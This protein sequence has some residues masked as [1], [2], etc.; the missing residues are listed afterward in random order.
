M[1]VG[2]LSGIAILVV[3]D[4]EDAR[5][6]LVTV[7]TKQGAK[8]NEA[9]SCAEALTQLDQFLPQVLLSDIGL[10]GE[11]GYDL[12]RAVRARGYDAQTLPAIALTA[13]A[14]REDRRLALEAG[15][16][17]HVAKPVEP[18]ELVAVVARMVAPRLG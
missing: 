14:R 7:L 5:D 3:E 8:V 13:Y 10:P 6:L 4:D 11:D 17:T 1:P 2:Q 18:A 16:Q 12:V 15:F 9:G